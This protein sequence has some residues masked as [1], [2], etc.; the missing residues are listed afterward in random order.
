MAELTVVSSIVL[1]SSSE[2]PPGNDVSPAYIL[3]AYPAK[4]NITPTNNAT[5]TTA[6]RRVYWASSLGVV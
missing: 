2:M 4:Q 3:N 5:R 1:S 6:H